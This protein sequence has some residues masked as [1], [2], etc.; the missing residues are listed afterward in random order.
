M[1]GFFSLHI[2][3]LNIMNAEECHYSD[4]SGE[5]KHTAHLMQHL[6]LCMKL[7]L[8]RIRISEDTSAEKGESE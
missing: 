5:T 1:A 7:N 2:I 6:K 3:Q 4:F 8:E